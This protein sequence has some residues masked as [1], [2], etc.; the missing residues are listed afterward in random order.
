MT[1]IPPSSRKSNTLVRRV[2]LLA[3]AFMLGSVVAPSAHAQWHVVDDDANA[4]LKDIESHTNDTEKHTNDINKAIG[5]TDNGG[6]QTVNANLDAINKRLLLG[7]Y[8]KE[9]PGDRVKDPE[10]AL[11]KQTD[12]N[13]TLVQES[14]CDGKPDLQKTNCVQIA[15]I[16]N[17]QYKYML[18]MYENTKTRDDTLRKILEDRGKIA[19][20]DVN[21]LGRLEENTNQLTALYN[22]IALDQQ[23]MQT[24]NYAYDANIKYLEGMQAALSKGANSG[25]GA[26]GGSGTGGSGGT[27]GAGSSGGLGDIGIPLPGGGQINIGDL[28]NT[29]VTGQALKLALK[30]SGYSKPDGY[31]TLSIV[32]SSG[33]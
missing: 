8:V 3:A 14:S 15:R 7:D 23:Q 29:F 28:A 31:K 20:D 25:K 33:W 13:A 26:P 9:R 6:G 10:Q 22:L 2:A 17:A 18:T 1:A 12:A 11:P 5:T 16:R 32:K 30:E 24:V 27:G 19:K 21:A 4:K